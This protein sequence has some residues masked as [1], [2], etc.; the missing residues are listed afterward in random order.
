MQI[1]LIKQTSLGDVLHSTAQARAIRKRLP[2]CRITLLTSTTAY[3]IYRHNP[4]ID[5]II[6]FDRYLIKRDWWRQPIRVLRH[7]S[8]T[9]REVRCVPYDLVLDLQGRWKSVM[10]L[11]GARGSRK[12]VKGRWWFVQ[13]FHDPKLHALEEMNGVVQLAGLGKGGLKTEYF[14]SPET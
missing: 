3:D 1:L 11:W 6:L 8:D 13:R 2:N 10:F 4:H 9:M 5:K 12:F 14:T 7:I